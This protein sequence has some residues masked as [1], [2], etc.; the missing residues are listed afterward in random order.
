MNM[1]RK[2]FCKEIS[3]VVSSFDPC[4]L[5]LLLPL[6]ISD[7]LELHIHAFG[8]AWRDGV[9]GNA[10]CAGVVTEDGNR[11]LGIA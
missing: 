9:V 5:E 10:N 4:Y 6:S 3:E 2:G 7:P 1:C 8:P 11:R